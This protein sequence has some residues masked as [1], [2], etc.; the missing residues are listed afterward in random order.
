[1]CA[2]EKGCMG[3]AWK[4]DECVLKESVGRSRDAEGIVLALGIRK[5]DNV[6]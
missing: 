6:D 4:D 3:V 1:M 5:P 2:G